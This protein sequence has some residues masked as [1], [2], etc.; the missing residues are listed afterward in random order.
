MLKSQC[1][2]VSQQFSIQIVIFKPFRVLTNISLDKCFSRGEN[3]TTITAAEE[4]IIVL[5]RTVE[6]NGMLAIYQTKQDEQ[7]KAN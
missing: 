2:K 5:D 4:H 1:T 3:L 6:L 7:A